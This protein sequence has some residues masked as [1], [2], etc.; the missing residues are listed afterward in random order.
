MPTYCEGMT[1]KG[2]KDPAPKSDRDLEKFENLPADQKE[3][4]RLKDHAEKSSGPTKANLDQEI[5][6]RSGDKAE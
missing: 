1:T 5:R 3:L 2:D 6:H 4:Q